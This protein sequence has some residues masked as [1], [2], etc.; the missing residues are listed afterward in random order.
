[1]TKQQNLLEKISS[2]LATLA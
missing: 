1:M 2:D